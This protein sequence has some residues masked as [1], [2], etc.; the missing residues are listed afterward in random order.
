MHVNL[1]GIHCACAF[2][3]GRV[4]TKDSLQ[5]AL[6]LSGPRIRRQLWYTHSKTVSCNVRRLHEM[7]PSPSG[8]R[9]GNA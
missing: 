5:K 3:Q 1:N 8:E 6:T 4:S 2:S 7:P 9:K